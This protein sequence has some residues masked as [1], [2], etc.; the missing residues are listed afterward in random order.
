MQVYNV[1]N[2]SEN[3]GVCTALAIFRAAESKNVI[4]HIHEL[5]ASDIRASCQ[6]HRNFNSPFET[7]DTHR[8][9]HLC[10]LLTGVVTSD[11][12]TAVVPSVLPIDLKLTSAQLP[13]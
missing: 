13:S 4:I 9:L 3:D 5:K 8:T 1:T 10:T 6:P 12:I 2:H 7:I 11:P